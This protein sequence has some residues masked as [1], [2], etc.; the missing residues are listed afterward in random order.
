VKSNAEICQTVIPRHLVDR[1][2]QLLQVHAQR[3][4]GRQCSEPYCSYWQ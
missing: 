4:A 3:R 2:A 1:V